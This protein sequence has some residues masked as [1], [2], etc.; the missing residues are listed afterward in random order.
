MDIR[1]L[2]SLRIET[3]DLPAWRTYVLDI[4][5]MTAAEGSTDT[6]L[7]V[8]IDDRFHRFRFVSGSQDRLL[9]AGFEV[10]GAG[11]GATIGPAMA[12]S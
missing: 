1:A 2:G 7:N 5:G 6:C 3:A 12:F 4:L 9:A 8:R 10:A 11:P